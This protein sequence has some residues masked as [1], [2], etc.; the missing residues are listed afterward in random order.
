MASELVREFR[1]SRFWETVVNVVVDNAGR[2]MV[3]TNAITPG[4]SRDSRKRDDSSVIGLSRDS[5][6]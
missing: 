1:D 4:K 5:K 2:V 3:R 6:T